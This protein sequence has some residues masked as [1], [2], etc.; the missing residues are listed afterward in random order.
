[1][2][3]MVMTIMVV[4]IKICKIVLPALCHLGVAM[5]SGIQG[6]IMMAVNYLLVSY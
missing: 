6:W 1:M 4:L 3:M 5:L 2:M